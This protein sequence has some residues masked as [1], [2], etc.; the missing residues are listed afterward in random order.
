MAEEALLESERKFKAVFDG[1]SDGIFMVDIE[2]REIYTANEKMCRML[3]YSHEEITGIGDSEL[4]PEENRRY[5]E[6]QFDKQISGENTL[7]RDIPLKR[8]DGSVFYADINS[9]PVTVSGKV[10]LTGIVRDITDRKQAEEEL[11]AAKSQLEIT[12]QELTQAVSRANEMA[13][14]AETANAAKGDF[15]TNVSYEIRTPLNGIIG[16]TELLLEHAELPSEQQEHLE[17]V[18]VSAYSL[19]TLVNN[20]LDIS[21]LEG[22]EVSIETM[23]FNIR[24][25]VEDVG[26]MM[27]ARAQ[28][29]ELEMAILIHYDVPSLVKGDPGRMR[30]ILLNLID[31]AIKFTRTGE[32][33]AQVSLSKFTYSHATIQFDVSDTGIG[34]PSDSMDLLFQPFFKVN[35]SSGS[36][37]GGTGLGLAIAKQLVESMGGNISVKSEEGKGSTFS[38]TVVL[39]KQAEEEMSPEPLQTVDIKGLHVLVA[40]DNTTSRH[41]FCEQLKAWDCRTDQAT[42]CIMA[43]AKLRA[44]ATTKDSFQLALIDYNMPGMD[45]RELAQWIKKDPTIAGT[46]LILVTSIPRRGDAAKMLEAGFDAYLTKPVKQSHLYDAIATVM[47]LK[48]RGE[49]TKDRTLITKHVLNEAERGRYKILVVDDNVMNLKFAVLLLKKAGYHCDVA[50]NGAEAVKASSRIPYDIVLMDSEMPEMNGFEATQKIREIEGSNRHTPI[51][52]LVSEKTEGDLERCAEVGMDDFIKKPVP[53]EELYK[54]LDR[55]L[56]SKKVSTE[57][58]AQLETELEHQ[59]EELPE[60]LMQTLYVQEDTDFPGS[61]QP[62]DS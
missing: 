24:T 6:E 54:I 19:L 14:Q 39:E 62:S 35:T 46:M 61:S 15:M 30:Q 28:E 56:S 1:T 52:G 9:S 21:K 57:S 50:T 55:Y 7:A 59:S 38:F 43:L 22:G 40:D 32:V 11:T 33:L 10:Y 60:D 44:A 12:N 49:T 4:Y 37:F 16:M 51:I 2:D 17:K 3:G 45:G 36:K 31:N 53:V 47:G 26:E 42:D 18:K 20:I 13:L 25:C 58:F 5:V 27:A 41:V 23:D 34:I 8:K 29:K 48:Q